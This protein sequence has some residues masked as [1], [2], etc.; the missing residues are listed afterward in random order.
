MERLRNLNLDSKP[1]KTEEGKFS[2]V[3]EAKPVERGNNSASIIRRQH[4]HVDLVTSLR[5]NG[6]TNSILDE[7]LKI[8]QT[9]GSKVLVIDLDNSENGILSFIDVDKFYTKS[10]NDGIAK[11]RVYT[12]DGVDIISNGYGSMVTNTQLKSLLTNP[13]LKN[14]DIIYIDCPINSLHLLDRDLLEDMNILV[15]SDIDRSQLVATSLALTNREYVS[16]EVERL[17]MNKCNVDIL[18]DYVQQEIDFVKEH[19]LFVN[20]CWLDR[21]EV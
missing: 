5:G 18:G 15:I 2:E 4:L 21:V 1:E 3:R 6:A 11:Q 8:V 13:S 14:Y 7:A 19:C 16:L 20:G 12:E 17:I 10:A 9:D